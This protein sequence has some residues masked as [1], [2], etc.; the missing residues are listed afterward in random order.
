MKFEPTNP[1]WKHLRSLCFHISICFSNFDRTASLSLPVCHEHPYTECCCSENY[2]F[3]KA[4]GG[5]CFQIVEPIRWSLLAWGLWST[6]GGETVR[7]RNEGKS[8]AVTQCISSCSMRLTWHWLKSVAAG[9]RPHG[10]DGA[11]THCVLHMFM[12]MFLA[13]ARGMG[14]PIWIRYLS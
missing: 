2:I 6:A 11:H 5:C 4:L 10:D 9:C 8:W 12:F 7:G 3:L 14:R 13:M 1:V